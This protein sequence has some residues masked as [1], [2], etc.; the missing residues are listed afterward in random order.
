MSKK[1]QKT[2]TSTTLVK[3]NPVCK[4]FQDDRKEIDQSIVAES[5]DQLNIVKPSVWLVDD[6]SNDVIIHGK[7]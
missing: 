6:H 1:T 7:G 4:S 5:S 3:A 2:N